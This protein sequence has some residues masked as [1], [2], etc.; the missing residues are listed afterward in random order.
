MSVDCCCAVKPV[1]TTSSALITNNIEQTS[2][3]LK[4]GGVIAYPTEYCFGLGCD[5]QNA[6]A[7][8]RLLKVKGRTRDQGVILIAGSVEQVIEYVDLDAS[9]IREQILASW[10]GPNTWILPALPVVSSWIKGKHSGVA[11]R[12][13]AHKTS[14]QLCAAFGGA[15]VSTSANRHGHVA[16][17]DSVSVSNE[18]NTELDI[19][20][21]ELVGG[22]ASASTIRDGMTGKQLR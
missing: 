4:K 9:P 17:L 15:L 19:I 3:A 10:P 5:P 1:M 22:A 6:Q 16:L 11:V 2:H 14:Q 8:E 12:V 7:V 13:T 21:D 20:L 18:M